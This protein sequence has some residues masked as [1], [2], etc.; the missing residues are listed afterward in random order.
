MIGVMEVLE[1]AS[2]GGQPPEFFSTHPNTEHRL[3]P[4]KQLIAK[5]FPD[6]VP[7]GLT[8]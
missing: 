5:Q 8:P 2:R 1:Q 3:T 6:G 7:E 4:L